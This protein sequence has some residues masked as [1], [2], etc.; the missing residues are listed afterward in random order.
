[1]VPRGFASMVIVLLCASGCSSRGGQDMAD[2]IWVN[3]TFHTMDPDNP[4][5]EAVA[6]R[7]GR[8]VHVGAR[9][10]AEALAG[11][12]TVEVDLGGKAVLPGLIDAHAHFLGLGRSLE[13]LDLKGTT[14]AADVREKMLAACAAAGP[15]EW[16]YGRG[17]DQNDWEV[18]QFPSWRD[19]D[20]CDN[21]VYLSRVD[22]H[23]LWVNATALAAAGVD[24]ATPDP[25]GGRVLRDEQG[26]PTGMLVDVA[27]DLVLQ[28]VPA[29][30]H[31]QLV[32]RALLA[33]AEC[34]R[35]GLTGVGDA[36]VDEA[37]FAVYRKLGESGQ[38]KLR[39]NAMMQGD[40]A[41]LG[42]F[43]HDGPRVGLY[44]NHLTAR[45]IKLYADGALGS[46]GAALLEPYSDD[47]GNSGL[48]VTPAGEIRDETRM[49][50]GRG[51]QV[52]T[53]AIGDRANRMVLDAYEQALADFPGGEYRLRV[54]H[55]QIVH[56]DDIPRFVQLG[57]L[58]SMQ[59]THATSDMPWAPD[60][61]GPDRLAGAYAWRSLLDTGVRVPLGS[62]FP[63]ESPDPLWG[64]H[65]AVTRQDH[66]GQP[67]AGWLPEQRLTVE[68]AVRGFTIDAAYAAFEDDMVGSIQVGK[69]ADMVV[70]SRDIM[71]VEP[72]EILD[73]EVVMTVVGGR[74]V[75]GRP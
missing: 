48:L 75:H 54:E 38:L 71:T 20:G 51:F 15:G 64:I 70:L 21:P 65:A 25:D 43:I 68:E 74:V 2:M 69:L 7:E 56:P 9:K 34:L 37:G 49:A 67:L 8:F 12:S 16:V 53:H 6:L 26:N 60:R 39:I 44:D 52:C 29:P 73:T 47:P 18:Q 35:V 63:V 24:E 45:S 23:A 62:D 27:E 11:K 22:G 66:Q 59:P 17:W 61:L 41:W 14:S 1:M 19:L 36:G 40:R 31:E 32:R 57:V 46:R 10:G 55:A 30:T 42:F 58:P 13:S 28:H 50:L 5:A 3:G 4:V 33:Q 72:R